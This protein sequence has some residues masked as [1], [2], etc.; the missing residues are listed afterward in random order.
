M[1]NAKF[2]AKIVYVLTC[3]DLVGKSSLRKRVLNDFLVLRRNVE[4]LF[5]RKIQVLALTIPL[6]L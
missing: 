2:Y 3:N 6:I 5:L 4:E 1:E